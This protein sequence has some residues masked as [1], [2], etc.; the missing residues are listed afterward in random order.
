MRKESI[1]MAIIEEFSEKDTAR[2]A[3]LEKECFADAWTVEMLKSEAAREGFCCLLAKEGEETIGFIYGSV[4]FEDAE[5]YKVAVLPAARGK[6]LGKALVEDW[7]EA[8]KARGARNIFLEVRV[9]N[10]PALGLYNGQGFEKTRLR[11]RYY[12]DGE[13]CLEMKKRLYLD[14]E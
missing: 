12:A 5:L 2:L 3:L 13:D 1:D 7:I 4:L 14:G 6:G 8:V 10:Q 11:K 9:S